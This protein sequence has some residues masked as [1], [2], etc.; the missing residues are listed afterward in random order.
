MVRPRPLRPSCA[1]APPVAPPEPLEHQLA[2]AFGDARALVLDRDP[3][4]RSAA[5]P[6]CPPGRPPGGWSSPPG[7]AAPRWPAGWPAPGAGRR[8]RRRPHRPG[9]EADTSAMPRASAG[10][11]NSAAASATTRGGIE[12][13]E[14]GARSLPA[15]RRSA[16]RRRG[17]TSAPR[18]VAPPRRSG[19]GPRSRRRGSARATSRLV[20]ITASGL[21]SSCDAS[22]MKRRWL[23]NASSMRASIPSKVSARSFSSSGGPCERDAA[24]QVGGLDL[25]GHAGDA[26]DR[27]E[28]PP[29][30]HPADAEAGQEQ[31]PEGAERVAAQELRASAGSPAARTAW[32]VRTVD[33]V[34]V[35]CRR[36]TR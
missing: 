13:L 16:G 15:G 6:S 11:S 12:P 26:V 3:D 22:W 30:H 10:T 28:H 7:P 19:A 33:P 14:L 23:S 8:G 18:C 24:R 25:A 27:G 31:H 9:S 35:T 4:P 20:R 17:A 36:M 34:P 1:G 5:S 2:L 21:R 29:G 32:A